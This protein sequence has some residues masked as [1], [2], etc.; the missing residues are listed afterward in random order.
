VVGASYAGVSHLPTYAHL[1]EVEVVA[2]ATAHE[3]TAQVVADRWGIPRIYVGAEALCAD[4]EVD[5]VDVVTRPGRHRVMVEE[6]LMAGK[7]VLCE[8]PF[9]VTVDDARAMTEAAARADRLGV[10]DLQSR[11]WPG[12]WELKRLVVSGFLGQL[13]NVEV[14]AFYPTFNR[15]DLAVSSLW[16]AEADNGASTLRVHGLHSADL[17]QW[18][19]GPMSQITGVTA[20]RRPSWEVG[21]RTLA[22]SSA[23]SAAFTGYLSGGA[24][25]SVHTSWVAWHGTGWELTAHGSEGTLTASASGHTGHFPVVLMG[26]RAGEQGLREMPSAGSDEVPEMTAGQP[27]LPLARLIRRM[28]RA[29][30]SAQPS[31]VA[32]QL[33][34]PVFSD[35]ISLLQVADQVEGTAAG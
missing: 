25:C 23:D 27:G 12:L 32:A 31:V 7:H 29:I 33:E 11:F 30:A 2:V 24:V 16:C 22:V 3:E 35:G 18:L 4:P 13:E 1:P 19:F 15:P 9:A 5:I 6:A 26:A 20:T 10:L 34:L 21:P 17:L 14:R 28:A 8:V